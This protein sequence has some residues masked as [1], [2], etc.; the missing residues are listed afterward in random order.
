MHARRRLTVGLLAAAALAATPALATAMPMSRLPD[1]APHAAR[2]LAE[3]AN[4]LAAQLGEDYA[5]THQ[6][7]L[8]NEMVL[9]R[10]NPICAVG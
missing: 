6:R 2:S 8:H 1:P 10:H 9:V 3:T 4:E 5:A 7:R